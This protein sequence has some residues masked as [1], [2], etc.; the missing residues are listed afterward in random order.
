MLTRQ[1]SN[2]EIK[3][4]RQI[5]HRQ[6]IRAICLKLRKL[7]LRFLLPI[8]WAL[9]SHK[10]M[11]IWLK[12]NTFKSPKPKT[13]FWRPL[14]KVL[15]D[16]PLAVRTR[17]RAILAKTHRTSHKLRRNNISVKLAPNWTVVH[18]FCFKIPATINV[19]FL[20]PPVF[21]CR[22]PYVFTAVP[23]Y[24]AALKVPV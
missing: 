15:Y 11:K 9:M 24:C 8:V 1:R 4:F 23:A 7:K 2:L 17:L 16:D 20:F 10:L 13:H 21:F 22:C 5:T 3:L 18:L 19:F 12:I 14:R 6:W